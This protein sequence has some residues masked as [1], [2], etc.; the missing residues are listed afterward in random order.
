EFYKISNR[1]QRFKDGSNEKN[2]IFRYKSIQDL[3]KNIISLFGME[4]GYVLIPVALRS[5]LELHVDIVNLFI[6]QDYG[7]HLDYD[8]C[9]SLLSLLQA[10]K[11]GNSNLT[12]WGTK[13]EIDS[14]IKDLE[15]N[16]KYLESKQEVKKICIK[17]KFN[18]AKLIDLYESFYNRFC[19]DSHNNNRALIDRHLS[20]DKDF[21]FELYVLTNTFIFLQSTA[22]IHKS[23]DKKCNDVVTEFFKKTKILYPNLPD[24]F[25]ENS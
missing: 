22:I 1:C 24:L 18:R 19:C 10:A 21:N 15:S 9:I 23:C 16:K 7:Y 8:Y 11:N 2:S 12:D 5:V 13:L 20:I 4:K 17:E 25:G 14:D 3:T 6:D